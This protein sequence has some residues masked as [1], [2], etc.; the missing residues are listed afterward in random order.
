[1]FGLKILNEEMIFGA[2]FDEVQKK[3]FEWED[4]NNIGASQWSG[5]KLTRLADGI[6]QTIG[7][8]SYNGRLWAEK[9]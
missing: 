8:V 6:L 9:Q 3:L 4:K 1:M 7:W 2:T 5:G